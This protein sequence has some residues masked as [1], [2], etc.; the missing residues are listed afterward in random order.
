MHTRAVIAGAIAIH[1]PKRF[2]RLLRLRNWDRLSEDVREITT[3]HSRLPSSD[4]LFEELAQFILPP[5]A[6]LLDSSLRLYPEIM[7]REALAGLLQLGFG[8]VSIDFERCTL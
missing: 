5:T 1:V 3:E 6:L 4:P 7:F 2:T 8:I